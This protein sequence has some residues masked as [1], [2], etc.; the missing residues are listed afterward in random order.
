LRGPWPDQPRP[1]TAPRRWIEQLFAER[2][3]VDGRWQK[4]STSV[5]NEA[6]DLMVMTHVMA[7]LHASRIDWRR[8]PVWAGEWHVNSMVRRLAATTPP[9]ADSAARR[10]AEVAPA[11]LFAVSLPPATVTVGATQRSRFTAMA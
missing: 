3:G 8:P 2:R 1:L 7:H 9:P 4:V 5:R 11:P 10:S 6:L